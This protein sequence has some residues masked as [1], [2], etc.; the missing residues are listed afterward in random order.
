MSYWVLLFC[1]AVVIQFTDTRHETQTR[2]LKLI[3]SRERRKMKKLIVVTSFLMVFVLAPMVMADTVTVNRVNGYYSGNGGEFT[4]FPSAGLQW[5][6]PLYDSKAKGI[7][8]GAP[9]FQSFCVETD[10]YVSIGGTY[11]FKVSSA[12]IE[13]GSGGPSPDPI[14]K[15]TAWLYYQFI[16]GTLGY[17]YDSTKTRNSSAGDLQ[18]AIWYLEGESDGVNNAYVALAIAKFVTEAGA[19]ADNAG[20]FPVAVLN[21]YNLDGSLAQDMLVGVP[22]PAS[23]LLLGSG[24]IG[25]AGFA[26]RKFFKK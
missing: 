14:S 6:L 16:Q 23:M 7:G 11:N 26:R 8:A 12:A 5:V 21:L 19:K 22:E 24:L 9:S 10:E 13:G 4:L 17:E 1:G 3:W 25:L 15:G 18:K 20:E 2:Y